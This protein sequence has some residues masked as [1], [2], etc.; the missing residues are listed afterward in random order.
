MDIIVSTRVRFVATFTDE[1]GT[2]VDPSSVTWSVKAPD[3]TVT[4][5]EGTRASAGVYH[6]QLVLDA[7]GRWKIEA[8]GDGTVIV[9]GD[10]VVSVRKSAVD[11]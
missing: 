7:P 9:A 3:G 1:S 4:T 6:L 5:P 2:L 10:T 8:Q 11:R